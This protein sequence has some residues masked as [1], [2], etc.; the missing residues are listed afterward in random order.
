MK[1]P[2]IDSGVSAVL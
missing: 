2:T 1:L